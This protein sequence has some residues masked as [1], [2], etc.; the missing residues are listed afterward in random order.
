MFAERLRT[1][2]LLI[3]SEMIEILFLLLVSLYFSWYHTFLNPL[4][5]LVKCSRNS[6]HVGCTCM[7]LQSAVVKE[8]FHLFLYI[9]GG[10]ISYVTILREA[11]RA[12][13]CS[14]WKQTSIK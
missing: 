9:S 1:D 3:N 7:M 2:M 11:V 14:Q 5:K 13:D 10:L 4:N 6:R 8:I 12:I